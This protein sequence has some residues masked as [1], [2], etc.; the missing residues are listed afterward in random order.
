MPNTFIVDEGKTWNGIDI[1]LVWYQAGSLATCIREGRFSTKPRRT[2]R[3]NLPYV[4]QEIRTIYKYKIKNE[5]C[6]FPSPTSWHAIFKSYI[7]EQNLHSMEYCQVLLVVKLFISHFHFNFSY[8]YLDYP[9]SHFTIICKIF[10]DINL[11]FYFVGVCKASLIF[12]N[13]SSTDY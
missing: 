5:L 3:E 11:T 13:I 6:L 8:L 4:P 9:K 2:Q 12:T 1:V 10:Y 7:N